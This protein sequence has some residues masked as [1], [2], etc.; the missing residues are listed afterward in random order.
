MTIRRL[1]ALGP[2]LL[3]LAATVDSAPGAAAERSGYAGLERRAIKALSDEQIADLRAGR[4][5]GY[6]LAAELNGYPGPVHVLEHAEALDLSPVQRRRTERLFKDMQAEAVL[7]GERLIRLEAGLER[8]FADGSADPASVE[9]ASLEA[10]RVEGALRATHLRY[11][12]AMRELLT[13]EQIR[14]YARLRGYAPH[15]QH[16]H[17]RDHGH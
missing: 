2:L 9:A 1:A 5:M 17:R 6:A 10:A 14:R 3:G 7:L 12:L 11:H 16:G 8:L 13:A 15:G 4:G